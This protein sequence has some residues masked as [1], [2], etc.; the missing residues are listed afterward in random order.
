M[1]PKM[2]AK[3][4]DQYI[5]GVKAGQEVPALLVEAEPGVGKTSLVRQA[6]QR[7]ASFLHELHLLFKEPVDFSG[8]P[9]VIKGRTRWCPPEDLVPPDLPDHGVLLLEEVAQLEGPMQKALGPVLLEK[10]FGNL[11]LPANWLVVGTGNRAQDRAGALKLLSHLRNRVIRVKLDAS[12]EDFQAWGLETGR[13]CTEVRCYLEFRKA[14]LLNF[15]PEKD[16]QDATPRSWEMASQVLKVVSKDLRPEVLAGCVGQGVA[17][18]VEAFLQV[19]EDLPDVKKVLADPTG[20]PIPKELSVIYAAVGMLADS[21]A[22]SKNGDMTGLTTYAVR[23]PKEF[24][25][26]Y[27]KC[28]LA[29]LQADKKRKAQFLGLDVVEEWIRK[30]QD[31]LAAAVS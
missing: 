2:L 23:L 30:N 17:S 28:A 3:L 19:W 10:R 21:V 15:V 18:E 31:I 6:A 5:T 20:L 25:T 4:L 8:V 13:I 1:R 27:M 24:S 12:L 16:Q 9:Q 26:L 22:D 7:A 11:R 29:N 14:H